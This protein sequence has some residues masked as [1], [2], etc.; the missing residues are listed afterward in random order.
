MDKYENQ[1]AFS[2]GKF[3]RLRGFFTTAKIPFK[4]EMCFHVQ[5]FVWKSIGGL[6][7]SCNRGRVATAKISVSISILCESLQCSG[8][9][10]SSIKCTIVA[11]NCQSLNCWNVHETAR[12]Q[13]R[14][15]ASSSGVFKFYSINVRGVALK[16]LGH[17]CGFSY[18]VSITLLSCGIF[19]G[20]KFNKAVYVNFNV[21][22]N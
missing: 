16:I 10:N 18:G 20:D 4:H 3:N 22:M 7:V 8:G 17:A 19:C 5:L 2:D 21:S 13:T 15:S 1:I 14:A 9:L 12:V 11:V 6:T